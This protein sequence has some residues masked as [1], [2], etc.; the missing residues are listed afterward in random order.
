MVVLVAWVRFA[1]LAEVGVVA[2]SALEA[3]TLNVREVLFVL[4]Q[5]SIAVDTVMTAT[6]RHRLGER[7]VDWDE[8]VTGVDNL[9]TLQALRAVVPVWAVQALV[10]DAVDE[11]VTAVTNSVVACITAGV[12][13]RIAQSRQSSVR[14]GSLEG[15]AGVVAVLVDRVALQAQVVVFTHSACNEF[16]FGEN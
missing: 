15:M 2:H 9:G 1:I 3:C 6:A 13:E 10:A 4:T 12:A 5:R 7:L 14:S 16:S 8:A 11:L